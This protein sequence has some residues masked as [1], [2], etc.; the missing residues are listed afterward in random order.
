[1]N[2][3]AQPQCPPKNGPTISE[4]LIEVRGCI[5]RCTENVANAADVE[6]LAKLLEAHTAATETLGC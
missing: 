6:A 5:V 1:M 2:D 4:M 3:P